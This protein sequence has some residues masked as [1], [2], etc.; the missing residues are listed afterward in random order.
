MATISTGAFSIGRGSGGRSGVSRQT[1]ASNMSKASPPWSSM[2]ARSIHPAA[3]SQKAVPPLDVLSQ[4]SDSS[5]GL[6]GRNPSVTKQGAGPLGAL[7]GSPAGFTSYADQAVHVWR[8][9]SP[10][11]HVK[12]TVTTG[13]AKHGRDA[14]HRLHTEQTTYAQHPLQA[15]PV[16]QHPLPHRQAPMVQPIKPMPLRASPLAALGVMGPRRFD[17][18]H[19]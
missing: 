17:S 11:P 16:Q 15:Q 7:S 13:A 5:D 19:L 2:S 10:M 12:M 4:D 18:N 6:A 8:Q 3:L 14:M 9:Q 1:S